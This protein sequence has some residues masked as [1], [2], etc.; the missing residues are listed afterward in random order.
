MSWSHLL[1]S[2]QARHGYLCLDRLPP[3]FFV[4]TGFR[5]RLR[6]SYGVACNHN[7]HIVTHIPHIPK[8][9]IPEVP[10]FRMFQIC[11]ASYM[12][13]CLL[14]H[15]L[16]LVTPSYLILCLSLISQV[17]SQCCL[18][19]PAAASCSHYGRRFAEPSI[20]RNCSSIA[21]PRSKHFSTIYFIY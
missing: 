12:A 4:G 14:F 3:L 2:P 7:H 5:T 20:S 16:D 9:G 18:L 13:L 1:T 15:D 21:M 19:L 10:G 11:P 17:V 8:K 6:N